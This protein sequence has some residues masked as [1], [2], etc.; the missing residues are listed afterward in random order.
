MNTGITDDYYTWNNITNIISGGSGTNYINTNNPYTPG[1]DGALIFP[2]TGSSTIQS[3]WGSDIMYFNNVDALRIGN[4]NYDPGTASYAFDINLQQL[5]KVP[6]TVNNGLYHIDVVFNNDD[7]T[8][9]AGT[10]TATG[11]TSSDPVGDVR[12]VQ[13]DSQ[14][15]NHGSN[16]IIYNESSVLNPNESG[17]SVDTVFYFNV[18]TGSGSAYASTVQGDQ[19][20]INLAPL[21]DELGITAHEGYTT[22]AE[23]QSLITITGGSFLDPQY[24]NGV[25][26][27]TIGGVTVG[28]SVSTDLLA[29]TVL[30]AIESNT[31]L[32]SQAGYDANAHTLTFNLV[33]LPGI[34][35]ADLTSHF[36]NVFTLT[37]N[38]HEGPTLPT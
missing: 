25:H 17:S 8:N 2:G 18:G 31:T 26:Q 30:A 29:P 13:G 23:L 34:T 28:I 1:T 14:W 35:T 20:K 16:T 32:A 19:D 5:D 3:G 12:T 38:N 15:Q 24:G 9:G 7:P 33:N 27:Q 10:S 11:G 37:D 22:Q 6:T 4:N 36:N 21:L